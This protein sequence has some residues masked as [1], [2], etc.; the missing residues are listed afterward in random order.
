MKNTKI[1]KGFKCE[2]FP[3]AGAETVTYM[4]YPILAPIPD[5][6]LKKAS[7]TNKVSIVMVYVAADG[8]NDDLTPWYEPGEEK[9]CPPFGGKAESTLKILQEEIIPESEALLGFKPKKKDLIGVSL[10]GLF[11]LWQWILCDTFDSIACLSGSFWFVG[12]LDWFDKQPV[13]TKAGKAF[14]L[15]GKEE[16]KSN[17]KAFQPVGENTLAIVKRLKDSG[18][19]TDFTWVDGN[20]FTDP[21]GRAALAFKNLYRS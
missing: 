13:P 15:L 16:P 20:H 7:E 4:I 9:G 11:T 14:F 8:W 10:S 1:I 2:Y 19:D 6:W 12:F 17:V 3:Y 18:I 21:L 5:E